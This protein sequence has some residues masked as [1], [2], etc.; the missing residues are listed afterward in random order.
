M[1]FPKRAAVALVQQ[2]SYANEILGK[3]FDVVPTKKS[4]L[5]ANERFIEE[6]A[7]EFKEVVSDYGDLVLNAI[8]PD[9]RIES[10]LDIGCGVG[11]AD[12][13]IYTKLKHKPMLYLLDGSPERIDDDELRI[14]QRG[15]FEDYQFSFDILAAHQLLIGNNVSQEHINFLAPS[16]AAIE[17]LRRIDLV[18]SFTSWFW[19]YSRDKYWDAVSKILHAES[20]LIVDVAAGRTHD[21]EFLTDNFHECVVIREY[22][23]GSRLRV[24]ARRPK[25]GP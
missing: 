14:A 17:N 22:S 10:I 16:S 6:L 18:I 19:H 3:H 25:T 20:I 13:G 7:V 8:G 5:I 1:Y 11:W 2:R 12:L 9:I 21:M 15:Y 23:D 24:M 4:A